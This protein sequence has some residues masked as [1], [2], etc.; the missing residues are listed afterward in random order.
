MSWDKALKTESLFSDLVHARHSIRRFKQ[1]PLPAGS[2]EAMIQCARRAP[3]PSNR[4]PVRFI[5]IVS[6]DIRDRLR[7][8]MENGRESLLASIESGAGS[9]K[10]RNWINTYFRYSEFMFDAPE[11]FA[12][13]AIS[14][15]GFSERLAA[16]GLIE[17]GK[18]TKTDTDISV[19]LA[20]KGFI[21][22][23][24]ELGL[25][26]CIL[27]APLAF[28]PNIGVVLGLYDIEVKCLIT[29][30]FANENPPATSRKPLSEIYFEI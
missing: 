3:S 23:A 19:G 25:G 28:I 12:A 4:Q 30:G 26:T 21:L 18:G 2:I 16:A 22:K 10:L 15:D 29:V 8:S 5:R 1:K 24:A 20:L 9:K 7:E 13:G 11:L 27:T 17:P 6:T 14:V